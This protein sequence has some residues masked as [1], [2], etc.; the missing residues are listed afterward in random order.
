MRERKEQ[1]IGPNNSFISRTYDIIMFFM[2][3]L[4]LWNKISITWSL[5]SHYFTPSCLCCYKWLTQVA[6]YHSA[7]LQ[8]IKFELIVICIIHK[9]AKL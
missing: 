2:L 9:T 1:K 7:L 4:C 6:Q 5:Y 3:E 8:N